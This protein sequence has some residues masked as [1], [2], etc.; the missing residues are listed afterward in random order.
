[1]IKRIGLFVSVCLTALLI[2]SCGGGG[3]SSGTASVSNFV[4]SNA[5]WAC[6]DSLLFGTEATVTGQITNNSSV[7]A[8]VTME[9]VGYSSGG[10]ILYTGTTN[11]PLQAGNIQSESAYI[12][13]GTTRAFSADVEST[14]YDN[15]CT[16]I[17][18]ATLKVVSTIL[19]PSA[20]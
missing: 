15:V 5:S 10:S 16:S 3:T 13:P 8:G 4:I 2:S 18:S 17:A 6:K 20:G 19:R 11:F 12:S 14:S 7:L 1:M 9:F